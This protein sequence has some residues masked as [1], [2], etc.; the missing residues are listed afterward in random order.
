V[1]KAIK[2]QRRRQLID[3]LPEEAIERAALRHALDEC[4]N[5]GAGDHRPHGVAAFELPEP[6]HS[7][8]GIAV[9]VCRGDH[10]RDDRR[11][12]PNAGHHD[13]L[14][15][16]A[17]RLHRHGVGSDRDDRARDTGRVKSLDAIEPLQGRGA[18]ALVAGHLS[19]AGMPKRAGAAAGSNLDFRAVISL[20][21]LLVYLSK[22]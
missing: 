20:T 21:A 1:R 8:D 19:L 10:R 5:L 3:A 18:L 6:W 2:L 4:V 9:R 13:A 15:A 17:V 14:G 7:H 11:A 12:R 22:T 16:H